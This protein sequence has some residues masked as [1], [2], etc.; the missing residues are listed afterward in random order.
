[1]STDLVIVETL[2]PLTVFGDGGV[3]SILGKITAE[4]RSYEVDVTTPAGRQ[5]CGSL[6]YRVAR[7]KTALDDMGKQLVSD[8]KQRSA[9][10]DA[11]RRRIR[12]A[13]DA[14]RDEVRAPLTAYE[15]REERRVAAHN[16][17]LVEIE[18]CASPDADTS[19]L[20]RNRLV[21]LRD[22]PHRDWEE[23]TKRAAERTT[24]AIHVLTVRLE[25][26][27][28]YEAEQAELQRLR[29]KRAAQEQRERDERLR[30]EA[31]DRARC[32]AEA[33]AAEKARQAEAVA[34]AE[35]RRVEDEKAAAEER[36]RKANEDR[37]RAEREKTQAQQRAA[38]AEKDRQVA[39]E[40]ATA[41]ERKRIADQQARLD[42]ER[43]AREANERHRS[44]VHA[45]IR[46]HM[47]SLQLLGLSEASIDRLIE[48]MAAGSIPHVRVEY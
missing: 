21:I 30:T 41:A 31:A 11:E 38:Q 22:L 44:E 14:L 27:E 43:Q 28:R 6:A 4:V 35:Q 7:S 12:E 37:L 47:L 46:S 2:N 39:A 33:D 9:K 15:Q 32:Q 20:I 40:R 18:A 48:A 16:D 34:K 19:Q 29:D 25:A 45:T 23:F 3:D 5:A 26:A 24:A 13:L 1:M 10:V 42:A 17:A 8:W 36:A